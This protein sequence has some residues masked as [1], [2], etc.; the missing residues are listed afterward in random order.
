MYLSIPRIDTHTHTHTLS[1][2]LSLCYKVFYCLFVFRNF[3]FDLSINDHRVFSALSEGLEQLDGE[4]EAI[5]SDIVSLA[6]KAA[7]S[8]HVDETEHMRE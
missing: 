6:H 3:L 4:V 2:S 7:M 8:E 1:L 5:H